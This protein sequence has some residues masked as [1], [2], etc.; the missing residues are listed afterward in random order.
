MSTFSLFHLLTCP[1]KKVKKFLYNFLMLPNGYSLLLFQW[2]CR[3][4]PTVLPRARKF[5]GMLLG[6]FF[7]FLRF[8][9][10]ISSLSDWNSVRSARSYCN[11]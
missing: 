4:W 11:P 8:E 9:L 5:F 6:D 1:N 3:V 10:S 7:D 2:R